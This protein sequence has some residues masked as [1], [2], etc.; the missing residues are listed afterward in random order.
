MSKRVIRKKRHYNPGLSFK[1][2]VH[3]G[4]IKKSFGFNDAVESIDKTLVDEVLEQAEHVHS[5]D[6]KHD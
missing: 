2:R 4:M 6:C 5:E 1:Q 3:M